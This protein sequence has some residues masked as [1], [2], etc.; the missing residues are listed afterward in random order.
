MNIETTEREVP[1][2]QID[3]GWFISDIVSHQDCEDAIQFL[4]SSIAKMETSLELEGYQPIEEQRIEW[5]SK[6]RKAL[7]FKKAA[8]TI[9]TTRYQ[10]LEADTANRRFLKF[11]RDQVGVGQYADWSAAYHASGVA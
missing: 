7:R 3:K 4:T 9:V 10:A 2:I 5:M 8:L 11:I 1:N 6:T